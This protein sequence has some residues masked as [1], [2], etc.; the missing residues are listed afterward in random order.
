M[1]SPQYIL[2]KILLFLFQEGTDVESYD[3]LESRADI[4]QPIFPFLLWTT[5]DKL[6]GKIYLKIDRKSFLVGN[7]NNSN[8]GET[9]LKAVSLAMKAHH[10]FNLA[11]HPYLKAFFNYFECLSGVNSSS[12]VNVS[13][14]NAAVRA[15][16]Q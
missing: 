4:P 1:F 10:V 11:Y 8:S 16:L 9:L 6:T 13:K 14:L 2:V 3:S 7:V 5:N 12:L 15:L